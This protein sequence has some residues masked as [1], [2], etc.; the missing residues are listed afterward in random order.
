MLRRFI[1]LILLVALLAVILPSSANGQFEFFTEESYWGMIIIGAL[2]VVG[3]IWLIWEA[4][5]DNGPKDAGEMFI[6]FNSL[7]E[8]LGLAP[9]SFQYGALEP[10]DFSLNWL[11][12]DK[13]DGRLWVSAGI[14]LSADMDM[15]GLEF[16]ETAYGGNI[17][18]GYESDPLDFQIRFLRTSED[19]LRATLLMEF[20]L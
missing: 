18:L 15:T 6:G 11:I 16:D 17:L 9:Q 12:T 7:T 5:D 19:E 20:K 4:F 14:D 8:Q 13:K 3:I 1:G 2:I 10:V